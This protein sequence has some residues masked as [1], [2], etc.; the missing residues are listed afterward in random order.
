MKTFS[1]GT[2]TLAF[3]FFALTV[4]GQ[5]YQ[6]TDLGA[7]TLGDINNLGQISASNGRALIIQNGVTND[8]HDYSMGDGSAG[9]GINN[10]GH[11]VGGSRFGA[12]IYSGSV[13]SSLGD[14]I[15][16]AYSINDSD[17]VVALHQYDDPDPRG[18][19]VY[20]IIFWEGGTN[21]L[22]TEVPII[23]YFDKL[24]GLEINNNGQVV[25]PFGLYDK[26]NGLHD[27]NSD[28]YA[29]DAKSINEEGDIVGAVEYSTGG[30]NLHAFIRTNNIPV[31]VGTLGGTESCAN[32]INDYG[33]VVGYSLTTNGVRHAFYW[34]DS[35]GM[36]DLNTLVDSSKGMVMNNAR[37]I[38][39]LGQI[40]GIGIL[41]EEER[42]FLLSLIP[43]P[44]TTSLVFSATSSS[45][46][47]PSM[48][49]SNGA[50]T[51][52]IYVQRCTDLINT[53]WINI[54]NFTTGHTNWSDGTA[55]SA[56]TSFY[57]R[58]VQ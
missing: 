19:D 23:D 24:D 3:A 42:G 54:T 46:M 44:A 40:I 51:T 52:P 25:G 20:T 18:H 57:Y 37:A 34:H 48:T 47:P 39:N 26:T 41:N 50:Y 36:I 56:W 14:S 38:N 43:E 5:K 17:Q 4:S 11:V 10:S 15:V 31:D 12:F 29:L 1:T 55:P 35:T 49:I 53:N 7:I 45:G 8:I 22:I 2:A 28:M 30:G 32:D 16:R 27:L 58:L 33:E 13:M 9:L 21:T 6:V